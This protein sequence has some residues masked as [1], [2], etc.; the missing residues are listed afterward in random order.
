MPLSSLS[1]KGFD[2][3]VCGMLRSYDVYSLPPRTAHLILS[4]PRETA[5]AK[6]GLGPF[7]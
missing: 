1:R 2:G 7:L 5:I 4:R 6:S 3:L